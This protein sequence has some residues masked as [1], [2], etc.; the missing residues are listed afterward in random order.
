MVHGLVITSMTDQ[1]S[2]GLY[3][4]NFTFLV[5]LAAAAAM[6]VI[7]VYVYRNIHLHDEGIFFIPSGSPETKVASVQKNKPSQFVFLVPAG[8]VAGHA[9]TAA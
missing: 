9:R 4:A 5:G 1:V 3:I 6:L 8:L 7:P 2:W